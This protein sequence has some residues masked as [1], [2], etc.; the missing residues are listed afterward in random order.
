MA[1]ICFNISAI[2]TTTIAS[3]SYRSRVTFTAVNCVLALLMCGGN[4]LFI[5][6][7]LSSKKLQTSATF[8]LFHL[9]FADLLVGIA[10]IYYI[11]FVWIPQMTKKEHLCLVKQSLFLLSLTASILCLFSV[12]I[13][14]LVSIKLP[15]RRRVV[16]SKWR[17]RI[18]A[19]AIWTISFT[20]GVLAPILLRKRCKHH[21]C[22]PTFDIRFEFNGVIFIPFCFTMGAALVAIQVT[23]CCELYKKM[24]RSQMLSKPGERLKN[25]AKQ[26]F[27]RIVCVIVGVFL[28]SWFPFFVNQGIVVYSGRL[29]EDPS[30]YYTVKYVWA[31]VLGL[32][33]SGINVFIYAISMPKFRMAIRV[34]CC[35]KNNVGSGHPSQRMGR[36]SV[37][38][39]NSVQHPKEFPIFAARLL[40]NNN[41]KESVVLVPKSCNTI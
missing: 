2:N 27:A 22:E 26:K 8:F 38:S 7:F 16:F 6:M 17:L 32:L 10:L 13:E 3:L 29:M 28:V 23:I 31:N 21:L 15:I 35:G 37:S 33:N 9:A 30:E 4:G 18:A 19:A 11:P 25:G 36:P 39:I 34:M 40:R 12:S 14:R 20:I 1:D 5:T 24:K 41:G